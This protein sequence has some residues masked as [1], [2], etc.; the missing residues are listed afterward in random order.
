MVVSIRSESA[1]YG[2]AESKRRW[3]DLGYNPIGWDEKFIKLIVTD[4]DESN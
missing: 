2:K 4:M 1:F 3:V